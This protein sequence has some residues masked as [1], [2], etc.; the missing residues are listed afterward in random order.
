M[1][2]HRTETLRREALDHLDGLFGVALRMTR[3]R[4]DAEDLVQETYLRAMRG[5]HGHR[6]ASLS[7]AWLYRILRNAH[8]D[9]YRRRGRRPSTV[10][11]EESLTPAGRNA[12]GLASRFLREST[13]LRRDVDHVLHETVSDEIKRTIDG[14]PE[15]LRFTLVLRDLVGFTYRE[16]AEILDVPIGTVMS[17]LHRAR[18]AVRERLREPSGAAA[19]IVHGGSIATEVG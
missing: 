5:L 3:N 9:A 4:Q 18:N 1:P 19:G 16:I 12:S 13:H 11:L 15:R 8:I 6:G 10:P 7:K 17:R 14:L 2:E